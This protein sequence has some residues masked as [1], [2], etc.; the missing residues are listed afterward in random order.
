MKRTAVR[1]RRPGPP[2][3]GRVVDKKY[4]AWMHETATCLVTGK[5]RDANGWPLE[6]HHVRKLA[7]DQKDDRRVVPLLREFHRTGPNSV[8]K[9]GDAWFQDALPFVDFEASIIEYNLRYTVETGRP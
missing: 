4:M 1:R 7:G 8:E 3:R 2:R 5:R 6:L 9:R